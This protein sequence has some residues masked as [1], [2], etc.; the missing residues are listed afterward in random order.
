MGFLSVIILQYGY[1]SRNFRITAHITEGFLHVVILQYRHPSRYL[2]IT[3]HIA[4]GF[5]SGVIP[6]TKNPEKAYTHACM[7]TYMHIYQLGDL[8]MIQSRSFFPFAVVQKYTL[9]ADAM[10]NAHLPL[11]AEAFLF[12]E[13]V[14]AFALAFVLYKL[15]CVR[16]SVCV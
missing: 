3:A 10:S 14:R 5:F 1:P 15:P 6:R 7:H 4:E 13:H 8:H 11:A 12:G 9:D 2:R 16:R